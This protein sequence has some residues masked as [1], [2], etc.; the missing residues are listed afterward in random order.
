MNPGLSGLRVT[1]FSLY[2]APQSIRK[3]K[4]CVRAMRK[5]SPALSLADSPGN[6][7]TPTSNL[8]A[9]QFMLPRTFYYH[10]GIQN[11]AFCQGNFSFVIQPLVYGS[12]NC[13]VIVCIA[14]RA[15]QGR[16][17]GA[18]MECESDFFFFFLS[19]GFLTFKNIF[20]LTPWW[21]C[22]PA[23][24]SLSQIYSLGI[25]RGHL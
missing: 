13:S 16:S 17:L 14:K 12:P 11:L 8:R 7:E 5:D 25:P 23:T 18:Q 6:S 9:V 22:L 21:W 19:L 4:W 3:G 2:F 24:H 20:H 10:T 15:S 1:L